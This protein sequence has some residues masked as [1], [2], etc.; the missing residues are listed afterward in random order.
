MKHYD[1][2]RVFIATIIVSKTVSSAHAVL[3]PEKLKKKKK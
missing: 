3:K 2:P 1:A